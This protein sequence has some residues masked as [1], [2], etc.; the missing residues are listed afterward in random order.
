GE[1]ARVRLMIVHR[2]AQWLTK[3]LS[4]IRSHLRTI[5]PAKR[6]EALSGLR[7]TP[8]AAGSAPGFPTTNWLAA[9]RRLRPPRQARVAH[10]STTR[11]PT[12]ARFIS[13]AG[14]GREQV[15]V[16]RPRPDAIEPG[17]QIQSVQPSPPTQPLRPKPSPPTH[18]GDRA[19]QAFRQ[20]LLSLKRLV[21]LGIYDEGFQKNDVPEQ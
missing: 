10:P 5:A 12:S 18:G 4:P 8:P 17:T 3:L 2:F 11:P 14:A 13:A 7:T 6:E 9:A 1:E 16:S 20:R 19:E 15:V 21:R